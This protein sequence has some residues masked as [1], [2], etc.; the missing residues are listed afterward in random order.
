MGPGSLDGGPVAATTLLASLRRSRVYA[1]RPGPRPGAGAGA[2]ARLL[3]QPSTVG[4]PSHAAARTRSSSFY[5]DGACL[6][7]WHLLE[8][9]GWGRLFSNSSLLELGQGTASRLPRLTR[10]RPTT[11]RH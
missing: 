6:P 11:L 10:F 4:S 3:V 5:A 1:P 7:A 2:R 9:A 8:T